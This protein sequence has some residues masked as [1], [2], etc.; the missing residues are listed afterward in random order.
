MIDGG[1]KHAV[2]RHRQSRREATHPRGLAARAPCACQAVWVRQLHTRGVRAGCGAVRRPD[3]PRFRASRSAS[4]PAAKRPHQRGGG[5]ANDE[6]AE[7][8]QGDGRAGAKASGG[9]TDRSV[10]RHPRRPTLHHVCQ[11]R[12]RGRWRRWWWRWRRQRGRR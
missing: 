9:H 1:V 5:T 7:G 6:S 12:Q 2:L 3:S 8:E 11:R 4:H 10:R